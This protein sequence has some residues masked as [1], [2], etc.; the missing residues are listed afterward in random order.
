MDRRTSS[1]LGQRRQH[2]FNSPAGDLAS[3]PA[4]P[5]AA[6]PG[7]HTRAPG[8]AAAA[9]DSHTSVAAAPGSHTSVAETAAVAG[10]RTWAAETAAEAAQT[11]ADSAAGT[12]A[13]PSA[14]AA[15]AAA[16]PRAAQS[17]PAATCPAPA[18]AARASRRFARPSGKSGPMGVRRETDRRKRSGEY[19]GQYLLLT[20]EDNISC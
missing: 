11:A 19:Y 20:N 12:A 4:H 3:R 13:A 8:I 2:G 7:W 15:A 16:V 1:R 14:S 5:S 17:P 18:F 9:V 10:W 6:A